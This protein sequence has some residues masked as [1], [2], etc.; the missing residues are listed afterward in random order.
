ML[1]SY[2]I[3]IAQIWQLR[4]LLKAKII[5]LYSTEVYVDAEKRNH[6]HDRC[7]MK[8]KDVINYIDRQKLILQKS[9]FGISR[10]ELS[11]TSIKDAS[12]TQ[13]GVIVILDALYHFYFLRYLSRFLPMVVHRLQ[14]G[15]VR[16]TYT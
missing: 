2:D 11:R 3:Y 9:V 7:R 10:A 6:T 12:A 8:C 14:C 13:D 15:S 4:F 16:G 1:L 5:F